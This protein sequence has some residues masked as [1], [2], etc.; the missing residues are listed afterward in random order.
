MSEYAV[1]TDEAVDAMQTLCDSAADYRS[2]IRVL[3]RAGRE[4]RP[5]DC[6]KAV[7]LVAA[8]LNEMMHD[9]ALLSQGDDADRAALCDRVSRTVVR[10]A[11]RP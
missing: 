7:S 9:V 8:C 3:R 11:V 5:V 1:D 10:R 4:G 6:D 2:I